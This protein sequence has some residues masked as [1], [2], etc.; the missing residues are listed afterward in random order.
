MPVVLF[1]FVWPRSYV[2]KG[3]CLITECGVSCLRGPGQMSWPQPPCSPSEKPST[4]TPLHPGQAMFSCSVG[5]AR[6]REGGMRRHVIRH[7][8]GLSWQPRLHRTRRHG[9]SGPAPFRTRWVT[10]LTGG[11]IIHIYAW[12]QWMRRGAP[13]VFGTALVGSELG[14]GS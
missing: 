8:V 1:I 3:T 10:A 7:M 14:W 2:P 6:G 13:T 12:A 5:V 4:T 11:Y 9:S